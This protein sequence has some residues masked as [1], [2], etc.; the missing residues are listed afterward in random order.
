ME[1]LLITIRVNALKFNKA[2]FT[3]QNIK[4]LIINQ[5]NVPLGT[6]YGWKE[7]TRLL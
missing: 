1:N 7:S 4:T 2:R 6:K 3:T 5:F